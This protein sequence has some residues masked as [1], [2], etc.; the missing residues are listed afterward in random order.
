MVS[1]LRRFQ[2]LYRQEEENLQA[3]FQEK[4]VSYTPHDSY[5][6]SPGGISQAALQYTYD[7]K[8]DGRALYSYMGYPVYPRIR[9]RHQH[10]E[11][12]LP[13]AR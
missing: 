8:T 7:N 5:L 6:Y 9:F 10:R 2:A 4:I 11:T 12:S 3:L 1:G 13:Q